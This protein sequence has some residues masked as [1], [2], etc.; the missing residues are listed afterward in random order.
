MRRVL[1]GRG[2]ARRIALTTAVVASLTVAVT[3]GAHPTSAAWVG[4][5]SLGQAVGSTSSS[6]TTPGAYRTT[7]S[8]RFLRGSVAGV[9][10]TAGSLAPMTADNDATSVAFSTGATAQGGDGATSAVP[11]SAAANAVQAAA[12]TPVLSSPSGS[13]TQYA[14]ATST[15]RSVAASGAVTSGG[16][17]DS[18]AI[19]AGTGPAV[20]GLGVS[21][22]LATVPGGASAS[23]ALSQLGLT[24]GSAASSATLNECARRWGASLSSALTRTAT[25]SG[26]SLSTRVA[27]VND[28]L[29][30]VRT[31]RDSVD[32][33]IAGITAGTSTAE[34]A[35]GTAAG[36]DL[37]TAVKNALGLLS[38]LVGTASSTVS[39]AADT[40][41]AATAVQD[42][43][44]GAGG[45]VQLD[46][47]TGDVRV[48]LAGLAGAASPAPNTAVL[49]AATTATIATGVSTAS[50]GLV[51]AVDTAWDAALTGTTVSVDLVVPLTGLGSVKA[52]LRG[53][54]AAFAAGTETVSGPVVVLLPGAVLPIG[55][56]LTAIT[57]IAPA[58]LTVS[59]KSVVATKVVGDLSTTVDA[60]KSSLDTALTT[61]RSV[62]PTQLAALSTL[63]DITLNEQPTAA[64]GDPYRVTALRIHVRTASAD[65]LDLAIASAS[66]GP[67]RTV[68][69]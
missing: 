67:D 46:G 48:D 66:V 58:L 41:G 32:T 12:G 55:L 24:I 2:P 59:A 5:T 1:R 61:A 51:S 44:S 36:S 54:A 56:D 15:G 28:L 13:Q 4:S 21:A 3:V 34:T 63:F 60:A 17:I 47:S 11:G 49:P 19:A 18:A 42:P 20:G 8:G 57:S 26:L 69:E 27:A 23:G 50:G 68:N 29:G 38:G 14:A 30:A 62:I 9:P 6:C 53:S 37:A 16:A 43:R 45:L 7:A 40:S 52:S 31:G 22:V 25:V 33:R 39:I 10:V 64:A 65:A 35:I